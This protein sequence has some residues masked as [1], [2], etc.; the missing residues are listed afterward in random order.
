MN[1]NMFH[2][3]VRSIT[4]LGEIVIG[5]GDIGQ[6]FYTAGALMDD[7][8]TFAPAVVE[9]NRRHESP[10]RRRAIAGALGIDMLA[11][12]TLRTVVAVTPVLERS[13]ACSAVFA[14]EGFLAGD[15]DHTLNRKCITSPSFTMYAFPSV[16]IF[17]ASF[18]FTSL[19]RRT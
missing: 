17:P 5:R 14:R 8:P 6:I 2:L 3:R 1:K 19:P 13:H 18:T 15:E 11:P 16:R 10:A 4:H 12:Q 9:S 7:H